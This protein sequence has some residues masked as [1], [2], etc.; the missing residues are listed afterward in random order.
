MDTRKWN[1]KCID[2]NIYYIFSL[3]SK[4]GRKQRQIC[5]VYGDNTIGEST[6]RKW[7]SRY[8]EDRFDISDTPRAGRPSGFDEDCLNKLIQND[9][10]QCTR[11]LANVM[12]CVWVPHA[13]SQNHKN[14]QVA[15]CASL[16]ACHRLASEQHRPVYLETNLNVLFPR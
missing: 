3:S 15:I 5:A 6:A 8:E 10:R 1:V 13:L 12:N 11:E 16:L 14:Q 4:E 2:W 9:P 7:F